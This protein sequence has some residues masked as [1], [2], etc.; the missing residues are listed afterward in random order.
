[1]SVKRGRAEQAKRTHDALV[2]H[3]R[4]V[5]AKKGYAD[6]SLGEIVRRAGVTKGALYHHF[7]DKAQLYRAVV[8]DVERELVSAIQEAAAPGRDAG[9][10]LDRMCTAYLDHCLVPEVQRILVLDAPV[11]LGWKSWCDIDREYGFGAVSAALA[12]AMDAGVIDTQ[13]TEP[14]AQVLL[15]ALNTAARVIAS[16]RDP[17]DAREQVGESIERLLAGLRARPP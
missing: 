3:A 4:K 2:R 13:P 12:Q 14:L 9:E 7:P 11:V 1:M 10:R 16:A 6:A 5:F 8:E 15:G 17:E